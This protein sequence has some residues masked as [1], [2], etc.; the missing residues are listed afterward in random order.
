MS[1]SNT[2]AL[3]ISPDASSTLEQN[4]EAALCQALLRPTLPPH[5]RTQLMAAAQ[6]QSLQDLNTQRQA[7]EDEHRR[8]LTELR[9]GQLQMQRNTLA[10]VVVIAFTA[11]A[12]ANLV[13][14]WL[15]ANT[16][17]DSAVSMPLIALAIGLASG[18]RVWWERLGPSR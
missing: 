3:A 2:P 7:L 9:T 17:L 1:E 11:G 18:F 13:V 10:L 4:L 6:T 12:G 15:N 16:G 5:F 14:P 8:A